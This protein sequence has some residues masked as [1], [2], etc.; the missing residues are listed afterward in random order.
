MSTT[1]TI[2]SALIGLAAVFGSYWVARLQRPKIDAE[3]QEAIGRTYK[4][5]V[6]ELR[7]EMDRRV[8]K[9]ERELALERKRNEQLTNWSKALALQVIEL[10]GR[11]V[12]YSDYR[13]D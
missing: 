12:L 13:E 10:G 7:V 3:A 9:L 1:Q 5:L 2:V 8:K 11:P 6:E 4:G